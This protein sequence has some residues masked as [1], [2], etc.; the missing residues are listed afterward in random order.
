MITLEALL[1]VLAIVF[2]LI[3]ASG[4]HVRGFSL[5]WIGA[6]LVVFTFLI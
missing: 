4:T 6:A 1:L 2:M 5:G 3:E